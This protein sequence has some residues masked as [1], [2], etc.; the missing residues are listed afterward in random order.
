MSV[1]DL[2]YLWVLGS[3]SWDGWVGGILVTMS[4]LSTPTSL[5][6]EV[7]GCKLLV[8]ANYIIFISLIEC[9]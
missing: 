2:L 7:V 8:G 4:T 3:R 6:F 5:C 1:L 9:Q